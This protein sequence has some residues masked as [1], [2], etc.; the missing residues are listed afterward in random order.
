MGK[1]LLGISSCSH[2][3]QMDDKLPA[4]DLLEMANLEL[5]FSSMMMITT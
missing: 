3:N 1:T 5:G 4:Y 2:Y